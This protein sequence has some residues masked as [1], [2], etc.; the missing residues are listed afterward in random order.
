[1]STTLAE[2]GLHK[3]RNISTEITTNYLS[4]I[5]ADVL[6]GNTPIALRGSYT[7][8]TTVNRSFAECIEED[9][10]IGTGGL[11]SPTINRMASTRTAGYVPY[12]IKSPLAEATANRNQPIYSV[13]DIV[14]NIRSSLSLTM[15]EMA[16]TLRVERQTVYSWIGASSEPHPFNRERLNKIFLIAQYWDK[17][18]S[19]PLGKTVRQLLINGK[20]VVDLLS[21]DTLDEQAIFAH[22]KSFAQERNMPLQ[23]LQRKSSVRELVAKHNLKVKESEDTINWLTG[24]RIDAD[25]E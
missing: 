8:S 12:S 5:T 13:E 18:L 1:M 20:S 7:N 6:I 22:L 3:E 16:R 17:L 24:K 15:Q 10:I 21:E 25:T 9:I 14:S 2:S 11:V 19:M 4:I 23:N